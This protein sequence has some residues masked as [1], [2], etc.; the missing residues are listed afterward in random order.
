MATNHEW[1]LAFVVGDSSSGFSHLLSRKPSVAGFVG[2]G[3]KGINNALSLAKSTYPD[4]LRCKFEALPESPESRQLLACLNSIENFI[5]RD[6]SCTFEGI[7]VSNENFQTLTLCAIRAHQVR[8]PLFVVH[9]QEINELDFRDARLAETV[10]ELVPLFNLHQ[11]QEVLEK[12]QKTTKEYRRAKVRTYFQ[13]MSLLAEGYQSWNERNFAE[14]KSKLEQAMKVIRDSS[15][16]FR[17][18]GETLIGELGKNLLFLESLLAN[19]RRLS[20]TSPVDALYGGVRRYEMADYLMALITLANA[21]EFIFQLR[22][23]EHGLHVESPSDLNKALKKKLGSAADE[24][25]SSKRKYGGPYGEVRL[26]FSYKPGFMD[27]IDLLKL[28]KDP[29][30]DKLSGL[31]ERDENKDGSISSVVALNN[32]RNRIVHK[33][34]EVTRDQVEQSIR[35]VEVFV[36]EFVKLT[37][38]KMPLNVRNG[39]D[40]LGTL[41]P[42]ARHI[43]LDARDFSPLFS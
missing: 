15:E 24:Y 3:N 12:I 10:V 22:L 30:I 28:V 41:E 7:C 19:G 27:M 25:F 32:L 33:M 1:G 17:G 9:D 42:Y 35:L 38:E 23:A 21:I 31:I 20:F 40:I 36:E 43:S 6:S 11:Y 16:D 34:G 2:I 29:L 13:M 5:T 37:A 8:V 14:S 4:L 39:D 18:I 26:G